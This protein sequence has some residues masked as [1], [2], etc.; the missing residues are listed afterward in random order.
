MR[1]H[2]RDFPPSESPLDSLETHWHPAASVTVDQHTICH[3]SLKTELVPVGRGMLGNPLHS[4]K[5]EAKPQGWGGGI[6]GNL[7]ISQDGET[8]SRAQIS[9]INMELLELGKSTITNF[10][11]IDSSL[12]PAA[13]PQPHPPPHI[14]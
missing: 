6:L 2:W 7:C 11:F 3:I 9:V 5:G 10:L 8:T 1:L 4:R 13:G 12:L 14:L